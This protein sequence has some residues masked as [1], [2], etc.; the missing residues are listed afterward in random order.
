MNYDDVMRLLG[1][2]NEDSRNYTIRNGTEPT[3]LGKVTSVTTENN[4]ARA[5]IKISKETFDKYIMPQPDKSINKVIFNG[6]ATIIFWADGTKT[7]VKCSK[8]DIYD[9]EKAF[10]MAYF[11]KISGL[12]KSQVKKTLEKYTRLA[13]PSEIDLLV[14]YVNKTRELEEVWAN[15]KLQ[16]LETSKVPIDDEKD[17]LLCR[18]DDCSDCYREAG[19]LI[20]N[21]KM[22]HSFG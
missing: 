18:E 17:C 16:Q 5:E 20:P 1:Y 11:E 9:P 4:G 19:L 21:D 22:E 13:P 2:S 14:D 6:L 3:I 12:N 8:N 10:L 7:I 15:N